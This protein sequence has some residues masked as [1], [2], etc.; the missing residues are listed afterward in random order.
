MEKKLEKWRLILG[1]QS[2]P[3]NEVGMEGEM[4]GM[5]E[6]LEALY[7]HDRK[8]GLGRASPNVNR[9][10]G[11]I[12]KY[13]PTS[14][15][16]IMQ[17]DALERLQLDQMLF[18]P[19]LLEAVE[20]DI[21]LVATLV[22]LNKAIPARTRET[23]RAVVRKVVEALEKKLTNPMRQAVE[24]ALTRS[25]RNRRPKLNEM[26]WHRT[27]RANLKNYQKELNT[28]IPEYLIGQG[29]RGQALKNI[30]LL[31]DQS[32]S[33][34][35]SMVYSS[36]FG[37]ILASLRSVKTH[38][39][40]FS[41]EIADLTEKLSDPVDLLFAAQLGGGTDINKAMGYAQTLVHNPADTVLVLISDLFEGGREAELLKKVA[42]LKSSGVMVVAILAL[43][44]EG[45]PAYDR[46]L[47]RKM[48]AL[49]VPAFAC[50][51]DLFP[52]LMAT[53][54]K[55]GDVRNWMASQGIRPK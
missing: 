37:A 15:V 26:D 55:K 2:D 42:S 11:D 52:D 22:S 50:T 17:K 38:F 49:D 47:S 27:I 23:A 8:G 32:G 21:H 45:A 6:V 34:A 36:V 53:A 51:P 46:E 19:E 25:V 28:I 41:T 33:M 54:L 30:I 40:A 7:D 35:A 39:V 18:E 43:N 10:L 29:R 14:V 1:K 4:A 20:P 13:F 44:D 48:A 12:R 9:W 24:G 31:V 5:D 16:Q 3:K